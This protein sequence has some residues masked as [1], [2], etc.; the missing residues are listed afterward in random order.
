MFNNAV[1]A[2]KRSASILIQIAARFQ[3]ALRF[4]LVFLLVLLL[5]ATDPV[6]AAGGWVKV[7]DGKTTNG[8][9]IVGQTGQG[10]LVRDGI[11]ICPVGENANLF[12]TQEYSDFGFKFDF[13]LAASTAKDMTGRVGADPSQ[14]VKAG[15]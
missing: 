8:W 15:V 14:I 12:T 2:R 3:I 7:F 11:L 9:T 13:K 6:H 5:T 1:S 4:R 10:Y